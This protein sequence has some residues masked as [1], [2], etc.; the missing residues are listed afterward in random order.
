LN[1]AAIDE[2]A[3][4]TLRPGMRASTLADICGPHWDDVKPGQDGWIAKLVDI[5]FTAR[6][7]NRGV[8]GKVGFSGKFPDTILVERLP[9]GMSFEDVLAPIRRCATS[10]TNQ[11]TTA[12]Y[13]CE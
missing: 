5:G 6:V 1:D 7:D 9:L 12:N 11:R 3:L 4:A 8:I 10:R 2:A 13:K